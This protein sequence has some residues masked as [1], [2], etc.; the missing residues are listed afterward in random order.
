MM[1]TEST[2]ITC[3]QSSARSLPLRHLSSSGE[4]PQSNEVTSVTP[5]DQVELSNDKLVSD[6]STAEMMDERIR[7]LRAQ[8]AAGTY[9]TPE[10]LDIAI[11][12]LQADL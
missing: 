9:L 5:E 11:E 3:S 1:N 7:A 10:K 12:R 2:L 6:S 8:I 4:V